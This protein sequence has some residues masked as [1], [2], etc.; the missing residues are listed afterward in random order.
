MALSVAS[1]SVS[2]ISLSWST[3]G[4][5][6]FIQINKSIE[7]QNLVNLSRG[8]EGIH[9]KIHIVGLVMEEEFHSGFVSSFFFDS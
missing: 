4:L 9:L 6:D 5:A 8:S 3:L 1:Q 7:P 2:H